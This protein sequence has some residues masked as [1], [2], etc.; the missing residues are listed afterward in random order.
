MSS[1][2]TALKRRRRLTSGM[3][4]HRLTLVGFSHYKYQPSGQKRSVYQCLCDCGVTTNV[5]GCNLTGSHP[6]KSCGCL[7]EE[8]IKTRALASRTHGRS[9]EP[10]FKIWCNVVARG[11][12]VEQP[13]KYF[14][15]GIRV[16]DRWL[17]FENFY[18]DMGDR[19]EGC[20]IDRIDNEGHYSPENCRWATPT[21][22][23]RNRRTTFRILVDGEMVAL[24]DVAEQIGISRSTLHQRITTLGWPVERAISEPVNGKVKDPC[25]L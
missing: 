10:V 20:S 16:C 2:S 23:A 15:R 8:A 11:T 3:R 18:A 4:F 12:G 17:K 21:Q 24:S 1:G 13:S 7:N 19:P 22:Q 25:T 9:G 6:T 5:S 14:D